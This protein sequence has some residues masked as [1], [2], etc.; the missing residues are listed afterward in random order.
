MA[1]FFT[2]TLDTTGPASPSISLESGAQYATQQLINATISTSDSI[3]TNYQMKLWG[4][5]DLSWA[6][7]AGLINGGATT[8]LEADAI[9]ITYAT[10]KQVQLSSGDG[11]KTIYLKIRDDVNNESAQQSDAIILDMTLP[12]VT[13]SGPD[14]SKISKQTGKNTS[15]FSFQSDVAFVEYKIKVVSAS[16]ADQSTGTLIPTTAGSTNMSATGSF[17]ANTPIN[18]TI[19]GADLES[20]SAGDGSKIIKIFVK[21]GAGNWSS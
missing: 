15:S 12:T 10:T 5:M 8:T 18:C 6:K 19:K 4:D 21:D 13:I 9:W 7:T 2:L 14:V 11:N 3:T 16:G 20:A 1:N 17:S